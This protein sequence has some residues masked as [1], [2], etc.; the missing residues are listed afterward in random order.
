MLTVKGQSTG[1]VTD[2]LPAGISHIVCLVAGD[3]Q[4]FDF[5]TDMRIG[6]RFRDPYNSGNVTLVRVTAVTL[7]VAGLGY[8]KTKMRITLEPG[9]LL[10]GADH[11]L[12]W[13]S[14]GM[15]Q[16]GGQGRRQRNDCH[17]FY[18]LHGLLLIFS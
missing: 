1:K 13:I 10:R 7:N 12:V 18:G 3:G 8:V 17:Q 11:I 6:L 9:L 16:A 15:S 4:R 14:L 2:K 5:E